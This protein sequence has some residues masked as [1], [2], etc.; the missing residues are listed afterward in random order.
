MLRGMG[1][2]PGHCS[3]HADVAEDD[4]RA[5]GM[6]LTIVNGRNRILDRNLKAVTPDQDA[7]RWQ[8]HG[9]DLQYRQFRRGFRGLGAGGAEGA[10]NLRHGKPRERLI[11]QPGEHYQRDAGL[12]VFDQEQYLDRRLAH[13]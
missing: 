10:K 4:D 7:T 12:I 5:N 2:L 11:V 6:S 9:S 3:R 13:G 8:V 1:N